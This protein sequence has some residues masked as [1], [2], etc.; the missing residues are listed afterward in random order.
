MQPRRNFKKQEKREEKGQVE[1]ERER[2]RNL[3]QFNYINQYSN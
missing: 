1:R 3:V 2:E